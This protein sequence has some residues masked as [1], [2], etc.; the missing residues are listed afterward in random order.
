MV[1]YAKCYCVSFEELG[2]ET[3][4]SGSYEVLESNKNE[5]IVTNYYLDQIKNHNCLVKRGDIIHTNNDS[6]RNDGVMIWNGESA[7][8]L[9]YMPDDYGN[10][11]KNFEVNNDMFNPRYWLKYVGHNGVYWPCMKFRQEVVNSLVF[12]DQF[13]EEKMWHGSFK[14]KDIVYYLFYDETVTEE[15]IKSIILNEDN[16]FDCTLESIVEVD[17]LISDVSSFVWNI[18]V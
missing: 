14:C 5:Q 10:V 1:T 12:D 17:N 3:D 18:V 4:D 9:E 13:T 15:E 8:F 11:P 7:Q 2:L 16:P 6:Y